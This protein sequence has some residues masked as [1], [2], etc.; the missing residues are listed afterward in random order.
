MPISSV[1]ILGS[2]KTWLSI[3]SQAPWP[4]ASSLS[5]SR[6]SG[7]SYRG[8]GPQRL[9][10]GASLPR[11]ARCRALLPCLTHRLHAPR[12]RGVLC[13]AGRHGPS[14]Q[15]ATTPCPPEGSTAAARTHPGQRLL[16]DQLLQVP[17]RAQRQGV[18]G[19]RVTQDHG[20]IPARRSP[21]A[22]TWDGP[23]PRGAATGWAASATE[24]RDRPPT[25]SK[26][27][28]SGPLTK[29]GSQFE[30]CT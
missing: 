2:L 1:T 18:D 19:E 30:T 14:H 24:L 10:T 3:M 26:T 22:L 13:S 21:S 5:S 12:R 7:L 20:Q 17:D 9:L 8:M 23:G 28:H 16:A 25:Q 4:S 15:R 29:R 27:T 11:P 6:R